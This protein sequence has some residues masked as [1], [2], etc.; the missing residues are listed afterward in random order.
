MNMVRV[1]FFCQLLEDDDRPGVYSD[2]GWR[3]LDAVVG[4][5]TQTRRI[6]PLG[7]ARR[8]R[9]QNDAGHSGVAMRNCSGSNLSGRDRTVALWKACVPLRQ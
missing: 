4:L 1:P 8:S 3:R 9:G 2:D 7:Y 6:R 5:G